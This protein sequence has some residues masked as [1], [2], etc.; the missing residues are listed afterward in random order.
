MYMVKNYGKKPIALG[1][2]H[3]TVSPNRALDLDM[4]FSRQVSEN[5]PSLRTAIS[6]QY[7]KVV[8]KDE[9]KEGTPAFHAE[10]LAEQISEMEQRITKNLSE[11]IARHVSSNP[12][13]TPNVNID[14]LQGV[15]DQLKKLA[16]QAS[17]SQQSQPQAD[18]SNDI[19]DE[20]MVNIHKRSVER[21]S[22]DVKGNIKHDKTSEKSDISKNLN[23]LEGLI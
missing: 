13:G 23:E 3:I 9:L 11:Q 16:E 15:V 21:M 4:L 8:R 17:A 14:G 1:D 7:L 22:R 10:K 20:K 18:S 2:L 19:P 12:N 5:S 6:H